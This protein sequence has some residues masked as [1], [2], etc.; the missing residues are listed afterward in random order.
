V[1]A[2]GKHLPDGLKLDKSQPIARELT[3]R[4]DHGDDVSFERQ[5]LNCPLQYFDRFCVSLQVNIHGQPAP[6][7]TYAH[8]DL[9]ACD[10]HVIISSVQCEERACAAHVAQRKRGR[11]VGVMCVVAATHAMLVGQ[12][13]GDTAQRE[14]TAISRIATL[15]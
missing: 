15:N 10:L 13:L 3:A 14:Y 12:M 2:G 9:F 11:T 4:P 7:D 1:I 8:F 6:K 5:Q